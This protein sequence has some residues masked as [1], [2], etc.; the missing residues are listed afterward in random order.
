MEIDHLKFCKKTFDFF[1][2][3]LSEIKV[4]VTNDHIQISHLW[5]R[6]ERPRPCLPALRHL[7]AK[8]T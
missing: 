7:A 2:I 6:G 3:F 8:H 5:K 1:S 4:R